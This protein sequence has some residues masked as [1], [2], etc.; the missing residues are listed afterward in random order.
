MDQ[1]T[2]GAFGLG[3]RKGAVPARDS[4]TARLLRSLYPV[5]LTGI[6]VLL[7]SLRGYRGEKPAPFAA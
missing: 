5:G 1:C 4:V 7:L 3:S 6:T 2:R